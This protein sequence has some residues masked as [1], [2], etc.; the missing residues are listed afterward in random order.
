MMKNRPVYSVI[1]PT[2]N[3][4]EF[5]RQAVS[6]VLNQTFCDFEIVIVDNH[7]SD[8]TDQVVSSFRD[9]RIRYLKIHNQG[10]IAASRNLGIQEA[11]GE[12]IAF[13]DADDT[14][15]PEKLERCLKECD[16]KTD[17]IRHRLL[18]T[19]DGQGWK[20]TKA[21]PVRNL[22]FEELL[23]EGNCLATSAVVVRR[24]SLIAVGGFSEKRN[25]ITVEDY[26]L[27]LR[28]A[29]ANCRFRL[30]EDLL[31]EYFWSEDSASKNIKRHLEA[32][33]AVLQEYF[34]SAESFSH[35]ERKRIAM[36]YYSAARGCQH[37]GKYAEA[38]PLYIASVSI[39]PFF[40][41]SYAGIG[42]AMMSSLIKKKTIDS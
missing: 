1:I 33:L 34:N 27:W 14:W 11:C 22:D 24:E 21:K 6:S 30:M 10:V 7:S 5:L 26:E 40:M 29:K 3:S 23:Y 8:H 35:R 15:Y 19:R 32:E 16:T 9:E 42:Q 25:F 17:V 41:R 36:A 39:F 38:I 2:Y 28:L 13:L 31:G 4:A 12:W 18:I 20:E 37:A